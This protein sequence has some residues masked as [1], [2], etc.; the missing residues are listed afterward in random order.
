MFRIEHVKF[1]VYV[2]IVMNVCNDTSELFLFI[3][4]YIL[5]KFCEIQSVVLLFNI[6]SFE[7]LLLSAV[8][9]CKK[10]TYQ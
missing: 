4:I 7:K 5:S 10:S 8:I 1:N 3:Y 2:P 9:M 6:K